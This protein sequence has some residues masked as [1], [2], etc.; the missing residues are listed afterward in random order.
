[1]SFERYAINQLPCFFILY[2][3]VYCVDLTEIRE[4]YFLMFSEIVIK[5][6]SAE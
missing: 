4:I 5:N 1:M 3:L 2:I 6:T